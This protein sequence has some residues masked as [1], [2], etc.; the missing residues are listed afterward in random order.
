MYFN[1]FTFYI[2]HIHA[3]RTQRP[4]LS[5]EHRC[6]V[7]PHRRENTLEQNFNDRQ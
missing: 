3:L 2:Q 7:F 1:I 4:F 6:K 5:F